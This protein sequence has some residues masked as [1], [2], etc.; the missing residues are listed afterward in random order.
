MLTPRPW[1]NRTRTLARSIGLPVSAEFTCTV[2][3]VNSAAPVTTLNSDTQKN[4]T[5]IGNA[6]MDS[7]CDIGQQERP[8]QPRRPG[9]RFGGDVS[10]ANRAFHDGGPARARPV[11]REEK[12]LESSARLRPECLQAR[13]RREQRAHLLH[14]MRPLEL[15]LFHGGKELG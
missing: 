11:A 12:I 6:R 2:S 1:R 4:K 7:L 13:L 3:F 15:R 8:R 9:D 10:A 14:H 5:A